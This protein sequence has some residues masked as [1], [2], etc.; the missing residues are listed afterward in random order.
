MRL[1]IFSS[2][3]PKFAGKL[4]SRPP[5]TLQSSPTEYKKK[6]GTRDC[7]LVQPGDFSVH[8]VQAQGA[9]L[10]AMMAK[11]IPTAMAGRRPDTG[12]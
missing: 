6:Y 2:S 10:Q 7:Y 5:R 8:F 4:K 1:S 11:Y 12:G 3:T 9:E